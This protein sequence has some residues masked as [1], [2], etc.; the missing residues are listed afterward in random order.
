MHEEGSMKFEEFPK[1]K[2]YLH[3]SG[4]FPGQLIKNLCK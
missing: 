3:I 1:P 4:Q 2:A